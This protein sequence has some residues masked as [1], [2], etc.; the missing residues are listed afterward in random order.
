MELVYYSQILE[1]ATTIILVVVLFMLYFYGKIQYVKDIAQ[2][3]SLYLILLIISI[4]S[5]A[6]SSY[7]LISFIKYFLLVATSF[8]IYKS[9]YPQRHPLK[10]NVTRSLL[11]L[12]VGLIPVTATLSNAKDLLEGIGYII[13]GITFVYTGIR[14]YRKMIPEIKFSKFVGGGFVIF[15][16]HLMDFIIVQY[17]PTTLVYGYFVAAGMEAML[18]VALVFMNFANMKMMDR[19]SYTRYMNLFNNS[20]DAIL[21]IEKDTIFDCNVKAEAMFE[22][23][24]DQIVGK[25][26]M[27]L[28]A[29]YQEN[30]RESF[31][32]GHELFSSASKGE[33]TTFD[34]IHMSANNKPIQCEVS[35][36]TIDENQF[37][38]I[39]RDMTYKYAFEEELNFHK[40]YDGLTKLPKRELFI[41]RLE[42]ALEVSAEKVALVAFNIDN[43]K[44]INDQYGHSYGDELLRQIPIKVQ[45][46]FKQEISMTRLGGDQ[47]V[48]MFDRLVNHNRVYIPLERIEGIFSEAFT[49]VDTS[50]DISVCIGV[51]FPEMISLNAMELLKNVDF[52]LNSAKKKGRGKLEFYSDDGM[53]EFN[54]RVGLE[55]EM[56]KGIASGEFVAYYQPIVE[57]K[58]QKI[59][60]AEA[61]ARWVKA[62][63]E[64]VYPDV[65]IP[66]AEETELIINIGEQILYQACLDCK[67]I[68]KYYPDFVMNVNLSAIQLKD[69][70]V[71]AKIEEV[72]NKTELTARHLHVELTE[73]SF[74]EDGAHFNEILRRIRDLGVQVALDD[75]G[76][77]YSSLSYLTEMEVDT[78][79]I[80]RRF[81]VKIPREPRATALIQFLTRLV[82]NLGYEMVIE[83][84]E[85]KDQLDFLVDLGCDYIQGYYFFRPMPFKQLKDLM[86]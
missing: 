23:S 42:R 27:D 51:A 1:L 19:I 68:L 32:Y 7:L 83:G 69:M 86:E 75:F 76:T 33:I 48:L 47:F 18:A 53:E 26:P 49:V 34:W 55:K 77:G 62:D 6:Y 36:F 66:V 39:I 9:A 57:S 65:F 80:D 35:F 40:Y 16:I 85:E 5:I 54:R 28:S 43:F 70:S 79:K 72:L 20:S 71:V 3:F 8:F 84:V 15:G 56:Q 30:G 81:I 25:T 74:I 52:A 31:E 64:M 37:A 61:L 2:A 58:T 46:V 50:I 78:I 29:S 44:E 10:D 82:H 11:L 41:D 60:G 4:I 59:I 14:W 67:V 38:A 12:T 17:S 45:G 13:L 24:K 73:T 22:R 21:M 63:G